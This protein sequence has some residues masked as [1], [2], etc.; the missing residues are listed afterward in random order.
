MVSY[1]SIPGLPSKYAAYCYE[2]NSRLLLQ[3][4]PDFSEQEHYNI[5]LHHNGMKVFKEAI[6]CAVLAKYPWM[7]FIGILTLQ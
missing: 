3:S 1:F 2:R 6:S 7:S 5:T 4:R